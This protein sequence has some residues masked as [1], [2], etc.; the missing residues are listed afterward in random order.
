VLLH[1]KFPF[2]IVSNGRTKN[3]PTTAYIEPDR[4]NLVNTFSKLV[5]GGVQHP[6]VGGEGVTTLFRIR[7]IGYQSMA[8]KIFFLEYHFRIGLSEPETN[9]LRRTS[10]FTFQID[11]LSA[12]AMSWARSKDLVIMRP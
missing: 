8:F 9:D 5:L 10:I 7:W 11:D 3:L 6:E 2:Y 12:S 1:T 4:Y